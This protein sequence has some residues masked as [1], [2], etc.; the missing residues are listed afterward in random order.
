MARDERG[1]AI[2][3]I[4]ERAGTRIDAVNA[5]RQQQLLGQRIERTG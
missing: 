2:D 4:L 1:Q 5:R 3:D